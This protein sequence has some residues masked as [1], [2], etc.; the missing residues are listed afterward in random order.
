[1]LLWWVGLIFATFANVTPAMNWFVGLRVYLPVYGI[2]LYLG[3]CHPSER[4]LKN[5]LFFML[6]IASVQWLFSLYQRVWVVP[7]RIASH[8]RGS[9]WDSIVG[10]FGGEMFGGG[11]SGSLGIYLS[12]MVVLITALHKFD[13]IRVR[14]VAALL[15]TVFSAMALVES[16]VIAIMIPLGCFLVYRDRAFKQPV[17][18]LLGTFVVL[19][20]MIGLLVSYYY[21]YWQMDNNLGLIDALYGRFAYSFDPQFQSSTINLGRVKSL[22]FWWD[23]HSLLDNPLTLLFGHG[24]ASAVSS[25]SLIG[26]GSAA[27]DTGLKLD[28]TGASKLLWESGLVG[29]LIFLSVFGVGYLRARSLKGNPLLPPWHRATMEGVEAAMVLMPL[30]IFYEVT[31]VSSPPMQ[32][33]AMF[34]LGYVMYW[35]RET[36]RARLV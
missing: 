30:S 13:Q 4:L 33:V 23:Q 3:Y 24:L 1:M 5:I 22:T 31:V 19:I 12:I 20:L 16:K 29:L 36:T 8:Y 6:A 9:P 26:A 34:F 18:F 25:S 28:V 35:W 7:I 14:Y 32:F 27:Q 11:E 10:S 17:K 2:F 15:L 21:L